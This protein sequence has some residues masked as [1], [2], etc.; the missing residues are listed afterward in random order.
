M[1]K[2]HIGTSGW[3]YKHWVQVFYPEEIK[4]N[5]RLKYYANFFSTVEINSTFYRLPSDKS[6]HNWFQ[7]VPGNFIFSIKA[8]QYI[9]HRKHLKDFADSTDKF[10][11]Q[12]DLIQ[13][14]LGPILFQLPPSFKINLERLEEFASQLPK[15]YKFTFEFRDASWYCNETYELLEKY[16]CALCITDLAGHLSPDVITAPFTYIRLHGPKKAYQGTYG[17]K[18]L[19][20]WKERIEKWY[21]QRIQVFCYFDNDEKGFAIQDAQTLK[22]L[23]IRS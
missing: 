1:K 9:T 17:P 20:E 3:Y 14:K 11:K 15:G 2:I 23:F 4:S 8:S 13:S 21:N 5:D 10:F 22:N 7:Q 19:N 16:H 18:K 12:V 6:V